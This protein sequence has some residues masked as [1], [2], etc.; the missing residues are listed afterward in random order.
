MPNLARTRQTAVDFYYDYGSPASYL[1]WTQLARICAQRGATLN[2]RPV[3]L[4][5]IFKA[6]G[7]SSPA[8]VPA[9][10]KY[11]FQDLARWATRWRVPLK[12]NPFFPINTVNLMKAAYGIQFRQPERFEEL[13]RA[14]FNAL[15]VEAFDLN[16]P[17]VTAKI[18]FDAGFDPAYIA[19][20]IEEPE[21]RGGI[22]RNTDEAVQRGVFGAPTFFVG[23]DMYWGQDRLFMV[24]EAI[25]R[26]G[27]G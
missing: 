8:L 22:R 17:A 15:W 26:A 13:N 4:G 10:G 3:V 24:E 19:A 7:N 5:A 27:T 16:T 20:L 9:K 11:M 14:V 18:L 6:T 23:E 25:V 2:Y 21:I 1:A 12:V